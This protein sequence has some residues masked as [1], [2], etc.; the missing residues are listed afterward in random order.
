MTH[1]RKPLYRV[2]TEFG[3][4]YSVDEDEALAVGDY[5]SEGPEP[6]K[7]RMVKEPYWPDW[8][9]IIGMVSVVSVVIG[10]LAYLFRG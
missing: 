3:T 9:Y 7:F 4:L 6:V 2:E 8:A 10:W 1:W 5:L